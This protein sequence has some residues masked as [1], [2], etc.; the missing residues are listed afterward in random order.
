M[1]CHFLTV[2]GDVCPRQIHRI[3]LFCRPIFVNE[4]LQRF[5]VKWHIHAL[6]GEINSLAQRLIESGQNRGITNQ[7]VSTIFYKIS[8]YQGNE[9][10]F[11]R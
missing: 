5:R 8:H 10:G 1:L 7:R 11:L 4:G 9:A 3:D 6:R 2:G